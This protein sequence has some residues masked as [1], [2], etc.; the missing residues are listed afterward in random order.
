MKG[1]VSTRVITTRV[2]VAVAEEEEEGA[3][4]T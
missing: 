4:V 2:A 1:E 3:E